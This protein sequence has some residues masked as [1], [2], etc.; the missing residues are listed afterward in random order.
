MYRAL[1]LLI[2]AFAGCA[3]CDRDP[4]FLFDLSIAKEYYRN[5]KFGEAMQKF[6]DAVEKCPDSYDAIVGLASSDREWGMSKFTEAEDLYRVKKIEFAKKEF[7]KANKVHQMAE[8][9]FLK[10]I[11]LRPKDMLAYRELGIFYYK[12][13]TSPYGYPFRIDDQENRQRERDLAIRYLKQVV[14]KEPMDWFIQR[15]LG[16]ALFSAD[17][18]SEGRIHLGA[19]LSGMM[20][21]RNYLL[22]V[23]P[24]RTTE[25]REEL[26]NRLRELDK[27]L[28]QI[29]SVLYTYVTNL[30]KTRAEWKGRGKGEGVAALTQEILAVQNLLGQYASVG[31]SP[32]NP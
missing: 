25:Q 24:R 26:S 29:R 32:K 12:R 16:L 5:G 10:A 19:Y 21:A 13:A 20:K 7:I 6:E 31:E 4:Q 3:H 17:N 9:L 11:Q 23:A 28:N 8:K 27:Q 22:K 30:E 1:L 18:S 2:L 15:D 14:E